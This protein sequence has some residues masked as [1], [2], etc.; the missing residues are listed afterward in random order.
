MR[1]AA[2]P[3]LRS[4][5][6]R[7]AA[8]RPRGGGSPGRRR[9]R[10]VRWSASLQMMPRNSSTSSGA[11]SRQRL[12]DG[13]GEPGDVGQRS[14]QLVAH[15]RHELVLE[16]GGP[17]L[18]VQGLGLAVPVRGG[19]HPPLRARR[20]SV[21]PTEWR[22]LPRQAA[23]P[24]SGLPADAEG[25]TVVRRITAC[26]PR[27]AGPGSL[28]GESISRAAVTRRPRRRSTGARCVEPYPTPVR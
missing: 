19:W 4:R 2:R 18:G 24:A 15:H 23:L 25:S 11:R 3:Q 1:K 10:C 26:R 14:P 6:G 12:L 16:L 28:S 27:P 20:R 13:H 21:P 9:R 22:P 17:L 5:S 7:A 8:V